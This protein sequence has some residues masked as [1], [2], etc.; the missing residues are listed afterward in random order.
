MIARGQAGTRTWASPEHHPAAMPDGW[1][2]LDVRR[3]EVELAKNRAELAAPLRL[4]DYLK[5]VGEEIERVAAIGPRR[6]SSEGP[7]G[8]PAHET[9]WA[10]YDRGFHHAKLVVSGVVR[11]PW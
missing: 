1:D 11:G 5:A 9:P 8:A 10:F 4:M 3:A 7:I 6:P 2:I